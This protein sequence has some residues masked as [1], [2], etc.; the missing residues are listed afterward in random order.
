M[1]SKI[2]P[3]CICAG[4]VCCKS[5]VF[6]NGSTEKEFYVKPSKEGA[7]DGAIAGGIAGSFFGPAGTAIGAIVGGIAGYVL[8]PS[9]TDKEDKTK[10]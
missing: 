10:K 8:G 1:Q 3:L 2:N 7:K 5:T 9:D 4:S 6:P